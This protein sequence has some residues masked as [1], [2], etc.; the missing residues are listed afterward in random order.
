MLSATKQWSAYNDTFDLEKLY[1]LIV[2]L[3]AR[4]PEDPW[5]V[6]TLAFWNK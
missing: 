6:E 2:G 5:V 4:D 1:N 3:F